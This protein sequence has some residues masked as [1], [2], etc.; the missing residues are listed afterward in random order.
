MKKLITLAVLGALGAFAGVASAVQVELYGTIDTG[1]NFTHS[2]KV[3]K[4]A[5]F[6]KDTNK[7][8]I[9]EIERT[10]SNTFRLMSGQH[11]TSRWGLK[12]KEDLGN[13]WI[14]GFKLESGFDAMTG[15]DDKER[16]FSREANLYI[17]GPYGE[18]GMGRYGAL[19][20]G[21]GTYG[22]FDE[23]FTPMGT[24]WED[25]GDFRVILLGAKK[26]QD[27]MI[28]Y[29]SPKFNGITVYLQGSPKPFDV[30]AEEKTYLPGEE[31][32]SQTTRYY[33]AAI[34]GEFG[35]LDTV[36][37]YHFDQIGHAPQY[38]ASRHGNGQAV[39]LGLGYDFGWMHPVLAA[40]W[41]DNGYTGGAEGWGLVGGFQAPLWG[42]DLYFFAGYGKS[43]QVGDHSNKLNNY[44]FALGY[45]HKIS[46][47][48][49]WYVGVGYNDL[50]E[51]TTVKN[52][53]GDYEKSKT[54]KVG[55]GFK[56]TEKTLQ[57]MAGLVHKF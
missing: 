8:Y 49:K 15:E 12:G 41:F 5:K 19:D 38:D 6:D 17:R 10:N 45:D 13:G 18:I 55:T 46:K 23:T 39:T 43:H 24:G 50:Q 3:E 48:T 7:Y 54:T 14:V 32:T 34:R 9:K 52:G 16:L 44:A 20:S 2:K 33:S 1:L 40:Q 56:D 21:N 31:G 57:F 37:T 53:T 25:I 27:N 28:T 36:I 26:R 22:M 35:N 11:S 29:V 51:P 47:R 30:E 42:G 4:S